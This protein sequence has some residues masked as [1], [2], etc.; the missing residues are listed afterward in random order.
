MKSIRKGLYIASTVAMAT[1]AAAT[2]Y[3]LVKQ[4]N[5]K[6][7]RMKRAIVKLQEQEGAQVESRYD[8][9]IRLNQE[10]SNS[11]DD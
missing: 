1:A 6:K 11:R 5:D 7:A 3:V 4:P 10:A 9:Q 2:Y 8:R